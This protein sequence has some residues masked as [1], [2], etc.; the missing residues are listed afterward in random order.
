MNLL[1]NNGWKCL[2][3]GHPAQPTDQLKP[4][5][6]L[7]ITAA[8]G[9][10]GVDPQTK[11]NCFRRRAQNT[12]TTDQLSARFA[13]LQPSVT[14]LWLWLPKGHCTHRQRIPL[15]LTTCRIRSRSLCGTVAAVVR[16]GVA[17]LRSHLERLS[18]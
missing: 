17:G 8:V 12:R 7:S 13:V 3:R 1:K 11:N 14:S 6:P 18:Q 2:W 4:R 10:L 16:C 15:H 5:R 9:Y